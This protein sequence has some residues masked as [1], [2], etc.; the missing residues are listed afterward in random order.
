MI[1]V[2]FFVA[3]I[4]ISKISTMIMKMYGERMSPCGTPCSRFMLFVRWPPSKICVSLFFRNVFI[5]HMMSGPNPKVCNVFSINL[6]EIESKAFLK[7]I[8]SISPACLLDIVC[9]IRLIR[10][11]MQ[12]PMLLCCRYAFCCLPMIDVTAGFIPCVIAHEA[13]L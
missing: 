6:C 12:L 3:V 5:Q 7:S 2:M 10:L 13:S 9:L 4:L 8:S 1:P 11:M